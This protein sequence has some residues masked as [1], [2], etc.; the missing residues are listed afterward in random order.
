MLPTAGDE[1]KKALALFLCALPAAAQ[2]LPAFP[3]AQGGGAV[4][5][6]GR[7][8]VVIEVT[9]LHDSGSGSL[10]ACVEASGPRICVFR[11][12]GLIT[13]LKDMTATSPFLTVAGQ[14]APG[15]IIIGGPGNK[16]FNLR[17]S[18]HDVIVRYITFS[19]DDFQTRP[20]PNT[21]TLGLA[22]VNAAA[23]NIIADHCSFRWSSNKMWIAE[24]L[25]SD[26]AHGGEYVKNIS[27]QWGLFYE[28][29]E[30]HPVG[31]GTGYSGISGDLSNATNSTYNDFHHNLIVNVDHRIP[32]YDSGSLR[33]INNVTYN[34]SFFG[35][36]GFGATQTDVIN[37]VWDYNNLVP[38]QRPVHSTDGNQ[39]EFIPGTPSFYLA[40]NI[41]PGHR[42][43]NPDQFG[44]LARQIRTENGPE[45]G[46][47]PANWRRSTPLP[48]P[49]S[50]K[51][52]VDEAASLIKVLPPTVGNSQ[53]L[54]CHGSW[55]SHR[56]PQDTR[57]IAQYTSHGPGGFWPNGVTKAGNNFTW[58]QPTS[59]WQDHPQTNFTACEESLHDGIPDQWKKDKGLSTRDPSLHR[60][61]DS[62]TGYTYIE[63]YL[64][65]LQAVTPP[66]AA[67]RVPQSPG[68]VIMV[69]AVPWSSA[70]GVSSEPS[71]D[72]GSTNA[73]CC[74]TPGGTATLQHRRPSRDLYAQRSRGFSDARRKLPPLA[75]RRNDSRPLYR[76]LAELAH[77]L[78][79]TA[80]HPD[81]PSRLHHVDRRQPLLQP[82]V[83]R[84][85][86]RKG[87]RAG[88]LTPRQ[89]LARPTAWECGSSL[90][91]FQRQ[92][93]AVASGLASGR[94][95]GYRGQF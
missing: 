1:M 5:A 87:P 23:Y 59:D 26:P 15:Q 63:E 42:T 71:T 7:G 41:G 69:K 2:S 86:A 9:N 83:V 79:P 47:F 78:R 6:G 20:G 10:R 70:N 72:P 40:G 33:W 88:P 89:L 62:K 32:E 65:G 94:L 24:T 48:E 36:A 58:P 74:V 45:T 4:S 90:P 81:R 64:N 80:N 68:G 43:P 76:R 52:P 34:Y 8:G 31:L 25:Y 46:P 54:D 85:D 11:V 66:P 49:N 51:I 91:L 53:H 12:A 57:I 93:A 37:N 13:P 3:G 84:P 29:H 22:F 55:V 60:K 82:D 95:A 50:Y 30:A 17:I 16:G 92:H 61:V 27:T 21:G 77:H 19:P 14:T 73:L 39:S 75:G 18:T 67:P 44:D 28:P 35:M 56:D 38:S